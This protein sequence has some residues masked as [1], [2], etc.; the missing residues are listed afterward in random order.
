MFGK[1]NVVANFFIQ[2]DFACRGKVMVVD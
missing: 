1:E 2:S